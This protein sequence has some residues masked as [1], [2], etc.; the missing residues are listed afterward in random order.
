ML[1]CHLCFRQQNVEKQ[2]ARMPQFIKEY[3]IKLEKAAEQERQ[4]EAKKHELL[5]EAR[6]YFGYSIDPRDP[7]F[8]EMKL[9]KEEEEKK[10]KKKEKKEAKESR[11][12]RLARALSTPT[13]PPKRQE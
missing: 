7:R 9:Q 6:D 2:M 12:L 11:A 4:Q 8:E 1:C 3:H 10:Q 5:E 13:K